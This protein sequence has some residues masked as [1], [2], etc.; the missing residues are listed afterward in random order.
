M[1]AR[2]AAASGDLTGA[3]KHFMAAA[4][5]D[6]RNPL[7]FLEAGVNAAQAGNMVEARKFLDHGKKLAPRDTDINFNLGHVAL[8]QNEPEIA[9]RC[10][11]QV[12][13]VEPDYPE[14]SYSLAE[15]MFGTG[16][17]EQ[18]LGCVIAALEQAPGDI[19]ALLLKARCEQRLGRT[20]RLKQDLTSLLE[21]SPGHV[22]ARLMLASLFAD[23]HQPRQVTEQLQTLES[24]PGLPVAALIRI[25]DIYGKASLPEAARTVA[26]RAVSAAPDNATANVLLA[27]VLT[28]LGEFDTAE[29]HFRK[30]LALDPGQTL[31]YQGLADIKRLGDEDLPKV[32]A[33]DKAKNLNP[34][35][36]SHC[37]FALYYLHNKA[38]RQDEAFAALRA[39]NDC[40]NQ[41]DRNDVAKAQ[42]NIMHVCDVISAD[43]LSQHTGQGHDQP[44]PVFIIGMP[45]SGTTLA[46]QILAGHPSVLAGGERSDMIELRRS[47]DNFPDGLTAL[48]DSWAAE[49]GRKVHA[50]MFADANGHTLATDKLPGN[51][52]F[53]GLIKWILPQAKFVYCHRNPQA[54]AL[55]L[56]EQ[57]FSTLPFS[58]DLKDIALAYKTHLR[59]IRHWRE[60]CG[61]DMFDLDYDALVQDPEPIARRL[62]EFVGLD[63][64]PD[65]LDI[66]KVARPISTASRWQA[67]QPINSASVE[68]W[69][70]YEEHLRPFTE[71]LEDD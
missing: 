52:A 42:A 25:G 44:G 5:R 63:W 33:L 43:F 4:K 71:A 69:R 21:R 31:A 58:R 19:D 29:R 6:K 48:P 67:R 10:F 38:H 30:G 22:D 65:Y 35:Q 49:A 62:Y 34:L 17:T 53:A 8:S 70:R 14:L 36:K 61:I 18:A 1:A 27:T 60:T 55:S 16:D 32:Q 15:A 20:G 45:R 13:A 68:R 37:G 26:E 39:A 7:L 54:N 59:L 51:Y 12:K 57:H 46:E 11:E 9:L 64:K 40:L 23:S 2:N 3:G 41:I 47:I 24:Q 66:T 28:D 56:F 50:A